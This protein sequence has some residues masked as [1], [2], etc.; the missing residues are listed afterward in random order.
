LKY[1]EYLLEI[2][3]EYIFQSIRKQGT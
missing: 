1:M 3:C 2:C